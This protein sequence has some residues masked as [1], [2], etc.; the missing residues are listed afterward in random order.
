MLQYPESHLLGVGSSSGAQFNM[1]SPAPQQHSPSQN[2]CKIPGINQPS[3]RNSQEEPFCYYQES[4]VQESIKTCQNSMIGKFL[5]NKV[6]PFQ[7]LQSTLLGIWGNPIGFKLTEL[8]DKYYQIVMEKEEDIQRVLKGSPW[9]IRNIWLMVHA[10][11]RKVVLKDLN[12]STVPLWIQLMGLPIHCRSY[13]MGKAIGDQLGEVLD[14]A[15]YELP[16]KANFVKIKILFDV[17]SPIRA[18]MYIGNEVDGVNWI[19]FRFE[20]LPMFCFYCGL[21]GHIEENCSIK[22]VE[23]TVSA[24]ENINPRGAWL[25]SNNYGIRV[26]EK[27]EKTFSSNPRNSLSGGQFSPIPKGLT[28]M[29]ARLNVQQKNSV[30]TQRCQA[31]PVTHG[32]QLYKTEKGTLKQPVQQKRKTTEDA[33]SILDFNVEKDCDVIMAGLDNKASQGL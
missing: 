20:N 6:I 25:R 15:V 11:D 7:Q 27:K 3:P 31:S 18:G 14:S 26:F 4:Y 22:K 16:D 17:N 32:Q 33:V 9:I 28:D 29:M 21:V 30:E 12:F 2:G 23:F 19:D 13:S 10:W 1:S 24:E 5:S 8:E